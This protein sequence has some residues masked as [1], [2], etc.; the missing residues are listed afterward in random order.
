MMLNRVKQGAINM[1][2]NSIPN[3]IEKIKSGVIHIVHVLNGER[4]SSGTGFM[5]KG[6][7]VTN[8]H[9]IYESP[10]NSEVILRTSN[11]DHNNILDGIKLK[12][13][14]FINKTEVA[15]NQNNNDYIVFDIPELRELNLYNF[16]LDSYKHKK[17]GEKI[18]FLGYHF[19]HSRLVSH[20]GI[21]SSFYNENNIDK[22]QLDASVNYGNSGSPLIDINTSKVIGIITR[23]EPGL[24]KSFDELYSAIKNNINTLEAEKDFFIH[25]QSH[26]IVRQVRNGNFGFKDEDI[27]MT[28]NNI[29][30]A[31]DYTRNILSLITEL[32]DN[33]TRL[34]EL[35]KQ[36]KRSANVGIGYAFSVEQL[37]NEN[38]FFEG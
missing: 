2:N 34:L 3:I 28:K 17:M 6:Y 13:D 7:L 14:D 25:K 33:S 36:I 1:E 31:L 19:D 11:S 27:S 24:S 23:K 5:V 35:T 30:K 22:I 26:D 37:Q 12:R 4:A 32:S 16:L 18:L 29:D 15:S 9:V 8:Y 21:I 10:D 38:C 20:T